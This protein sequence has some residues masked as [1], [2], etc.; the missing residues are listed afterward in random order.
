MGFEEPF[1]KKDMPQRFTYLFEQY[2]SQSLTEQEKQEFLALLQTTDYD[3]LLQELIDNRYAN[4]DAKNS[5]FTVESEQRMLYNIF[6]YRTPTASNPLPKTITRRLFPRWAI[7]ASIALA[8]MAG[9]YYYY[10]S[11]IVDIKT[12]IVYANDIAPG[13]N[14]ATLT[15]ANGQK[16]LINDALTGNI[17]TQSGVKISKTADGELVYE[18]TADNSKILTYNTLATTRGEQTRV[19]LPDGTLVF[20]NAESSLKYPTRFA[21]MAKREVSLTGEGYFEVAKDKTHPFI[22]STE[23]Q[24]VEVLGTHFNINSYADEAGLKTTLIEGSVKVSGSNSFKILKPGQQS[25]LSPNGNLLVAEADIETVVAWKNNQFMFDSEN[26]QTVMRMVERWYNVEV[27]Y[28]GEIT[29]EKFGGGVSKFDNVSKVLTSLQSTGK[30]HFK[31]E[32]K[33]IYVSK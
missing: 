4:F 21:G 20:L 25:I 31:I 33:K 8:V 13:K 10:Q 14:G 6:N 18:L 22:V 7:A 23:K 28:V 29:D 12:E 30:V 17:A 27:E 16:I 19:R 11:K 1:K 24:A 3:T 2:F 15:L 9:S 26:I 5:P 32:G